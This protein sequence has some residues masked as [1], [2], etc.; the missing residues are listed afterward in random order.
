MIIERL[1]AER[2]VNQSVPL[3]L[4]TPV[5]LLAVLGILQAG[6]WLHADTVATRAAQ[7]AVDVGRSAHAADNDGV[8]VVDRIAAAGGLTAVRTSIR[9]SPERVTV[10]VRADAPWVLVPLQV[11][12]TASAPRERVSQP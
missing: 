5:L 9:R 2:G 12:A 4:V 3:A 8:A 7:A 1:S 11:E 6:L 10:V